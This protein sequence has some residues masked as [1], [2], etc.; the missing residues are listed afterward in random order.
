[1]MSPLDGHS[2]PPWPDLSFEEAL[3]RRGALLVAG[4]DEAGRGA[5][6]GPVVAAA[7][8]LPPEPSLS[9]SLRGV[10]DSKQMSPQERERWA[11]LLKEVAL[12]W[13]VGFAQV[14]EIDELGI[15]PATRL[16]MRRA[17]EQLRVQPQH[18][19]VD[20]FTLPEVNIPQTALVKGDGRALSIAAASILA[21]TARD[22]CLRQLDRDYPGYGLARHKGY[23][24]AAHLEALAR[25]G[26]SPAHRR[27]FSPVRQD[28]LAL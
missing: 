16:A 28:K 14:E 6:A 15:A 12:A 11:P 9:Q 27:S 4:M 8:I 19:L 7:L 2:V 1:M 3:W 5:L 10:R 13:G 17:L 24:T 26:P 18:L 25:L 21:K 22:A 20:Y 23:G